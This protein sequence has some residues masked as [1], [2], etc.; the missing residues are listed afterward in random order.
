MPAIVK[1]PGAEISQ[2]RQLN[3]KC[4]FFSTK[5]NMFVPFDDIE[6]WPLITN[7]LCTQINLNDLLP[8]LTQIITKIAWTIKRGKLTSGSRVPID[9]C[10]SFGANSRKVSAHALNAWARPGVGV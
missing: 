5:C 2:V 6:L 3:H 9:E 1:E 8:K 4:I 10:Q 7:V